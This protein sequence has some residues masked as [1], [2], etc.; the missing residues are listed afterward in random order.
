MWAGSIG[1]RHVWISLLHTALNN[2]VNPV[3]MVLTC[4][5]MSASI[6]PLKL[7]FDYVL[8]SMLIE[9]P[10]TNVLIRQASQFSI[11]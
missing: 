1:V 4:M 11:Q 8:M 3:L 7:E 5:L 2:K 9:N 10:D 6:L